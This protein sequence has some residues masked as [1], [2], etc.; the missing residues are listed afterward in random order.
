MTQHSTIKLV[1][2]LGNPGSEYAQTRHNAGFWFAEQL[3]TSYKINL[4]NEGKFKGLLGICENS[5]EPF[6]VL[7]PQTYMNLSGQSVQAL[8][9]FYKILP[10]EVLIVHDELDLEPGIARLK[11]DG[12]GG[13]HNGLKDL[14][15]RLGTKAFYRL[16]LGIGHPKVRELVHDYVLHKPSVDD[17]NKIFQAID[18]SLRVFPE[19]LQGKMNDAMKT[20]HTEKK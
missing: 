4:K 2:G 3:C 9:Q 17:R 12:G 19:I 14:I 13:G 16:R 8:C 15:A 20:L 6:R 18:D 11:F 10:Q 5:P 7:L 1:V